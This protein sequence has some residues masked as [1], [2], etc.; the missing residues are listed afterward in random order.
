MTN[1]SSSDYGPSSLQH[2]RGMDAIRLR[3]NMYVGGRDSIGLHHY[4]FA[5]LDFM[6]NIAIEGKCHNIWVTLR[7][8]NEVTIHNDSV[9]PIL[10]VDHHQFNG[11]PILELM[12]EMVGSGR[13]SWDQY[14]VEGG[15]HGVGLPAVT[16]L[17]AEMTVETIQD[18]Y[19][20]R[21]SYAASWPTSE[22]QKIRPANPDEKGITFILK[23]DYTLFDSNPI[24][25]DV[26]A[27]R[28]QEVAYQIHD[29]RFIVR[30][31]TCHPPKEEIFCPA[32]GLKSW[33]AD[34]NDGQTPLHEPIHIRDVVIFKYSDGSPYIIEVEFACQFTDSI[35]SKILSYVNTV[36][37]SSGVH[38]EAMQ[39]AIFN[40]LN[41]ML[42]TQHLSSE[43]VPFTWAEVS[44]GLNVIIA[45]LHPDP[46]YLSQTQME[47][48]NPEV[49]EAVAT[50]LATTFGLTSTKD[51]LAT[52]FF[53]LLNRRT[54]NSSNPNP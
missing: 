25:F 53:H 19:L 2:L 26:L 30:D 12:L 35:E 37:T 23:P 41:T 15:V 46:Q 17:S 44:A 51:T 50:V 39:T 43:P 38:I 49:Y 52:V 20:W 36:A 5:V 32:D 28:C 22:L 1:P 13:Y 11:E 48:M 31:E 21:K 27:R 45:I 34:L 42:A 7:Q 18:G 3:P 54:S 4:L 6:I 16:A 47:L 40:E 24:S 14:R 33:V 29:L 9:D 8:D 10:N